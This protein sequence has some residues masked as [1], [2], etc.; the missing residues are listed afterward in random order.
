MNALFAALLAASAV[1]AVP[2]PGMGVP[3]TLQVLVVVLVALI[4]PPSWAALA[5]GTYLLAGAVGLPVFAR[6]HGGLA[7]L[8]G[9]SGGY[10]IGFLLGA[11]AGSWV[12]SRLATNQRFMLGDV[13]AAV[14]VVACSYL[15]GWLHLMLVTGTG[16]LA[17]LLGGVVPFV[18]PDVL[19]AIGA[20]VMAPMVRKASGL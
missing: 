18:V 19:K 14:I 10:L 2:V 7:V 12:R 13:S 15:V 4:V 6:A 17:A 11:V 1:L 5:L 9:P 8:L 20:V 3:L 16:P